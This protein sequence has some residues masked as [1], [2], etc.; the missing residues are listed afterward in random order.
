MGQ[1]LPTA[2]YLK[3]IMSYQRKEGCIELGIITFFY[4]ALYKDDGQSAFNKWLC[5]ALK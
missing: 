2:K 1:M 5:S 4:Q 3:G